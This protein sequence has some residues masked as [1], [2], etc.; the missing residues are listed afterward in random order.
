[1]G[2]SVV[3]YP[4][5]VWYGRVTLESADEIFYEHIINGRPV[6]RLLLQ[7]LQGVGPGEPSS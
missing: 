2:V 5:G 7:T 1:M 4:Q 6:K 3:V